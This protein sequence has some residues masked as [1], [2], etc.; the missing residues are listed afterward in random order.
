LGKHI[1]FRPAP[2]WFG[3]DD[4]PVHVENNGPGT[5]WFWVSFW[6]SPINA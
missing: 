6:F 3:V 4:D 1:H 2:Q 5:H